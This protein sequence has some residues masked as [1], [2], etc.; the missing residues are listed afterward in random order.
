MCSFLCTSWAHTKAIA[1]IFVQGFDLPSLPFP[2]PSPYSFPLN[3][4]RGLG[5]AVSSPSGVRGRAPAANAFWSIYCSQNTS[6]GNIFQSLMHNAVGMFFVE[7][8]R[9]KNSQH[10][11]GG[12][13]NPLTFPLN[14]ALACTAKSQGLGYN[15]RYIENNIPPAHCTKCSIRL[16]QSDECCSNLCLGLS[17]SSDTRPSFIPQII[18][19]QLRRSK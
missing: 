17:S 16:H 5:N 9:E 8:P 14:T 11:G 6:R 12:E 3:P 18:T 13:L 2:S 15:R 1:R 19:P 4:A 7:L 10:F